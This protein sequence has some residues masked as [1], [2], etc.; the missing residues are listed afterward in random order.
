VAYLNFTGHPQACLRR[1]AEAVAEGL[2]I[3]GAVGA[4]EDVSAA[5]VAVVPTFASSKTFVPL[6]RL[7]NGLEVYRFR[8]KG[9]DHTAYV[10]VMA[11]EVQKSN[12]GQFGA[13][14]KDI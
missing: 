6:V 1:S 4:A 9:S 8:Y 11:Q 7:N 5:V 13:I 3:L 14:T 2:H 10:G 12:P